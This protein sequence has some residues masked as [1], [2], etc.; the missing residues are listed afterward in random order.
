M[1]V[2]MNTLHELKAGVDILADA[3]SVTMGPK[4]R[5]VVI[6]KPNQDLKVTKDGV[7]V[8][9][10]IED[11]E[12]PLHE[13]GAKM[14][15]E[16][17]SR[18]GNLAG[19]GTT[20]ATVLTQA[21]IAEGVK[22]IA[23]GANPI[24]IKRG[25]DKAVAEVVDNLKEMSTSIALG[26]EELRQVATI[27]ANN[28]SELGE[29]LADAFESV[30]SAGVVSVEDS[31]SHKT[32]VDVVTGMQFD[33]GY[34]SPLSTTNPTGT[35]CELENPM[36][37]LYDGK[38]TSMDKIVIVMGL[39][40]KLGRPLVV[41]A[42]DIN[43]TALVQLNVNIVHNAL[44]SVAIKAPGFSESR[45][46]LLLDIGIVTNSVVFSDEGQLTLDHITD[47]N[48]DELM[49]GGSE[50][51]TVENTST[52]IVNGNGDASKIVAR[53]ETIEKMIE[54]ADSDHERKQLHSR[55]AKLTGGVGVL[56]IGANSPVEAKEK[57]DRADDA[58]CAVRAA[59]EEGVVPGGGL[60]LLNASK[61]LVPGSVGSNI[62]IEACKRPM[63]V[64]AENSG[65][66]GDVV[67]AETNSQE[68]G[69]GYNAKTGEYVYLYAEGIIDPTKVTRIALESA[70]SAAGM[71]IL[72][73]CA[74]Y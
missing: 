23:A 74:I 14:V 18:A 52:V 17:A 9:E 69:V 12:N 28:D 61:S 47:E 68:D 58:L 38:I 21:M 11:L 10:A 55:V 63:K 65:I 49:F 13:I 16:V 4:G 70:V 59:I 30:G 8:A 36:Y 56:Y 3:V 39:A 37:F 19:D 62:I 6:H 26:G 54:E 40:K 32:Y 24:N 50:G 72:T 44:R 48:I 35:T 29:L 15:K 33:R 43:G 27:S 57:R 45:G 1:K 66:N 31:R 20:T 51:I 5:N 41:I 2:E 60:A 46:E 64:I 53:A 25:M 34:I 71:V 7:T 42:E 67:V 73:E 22:N